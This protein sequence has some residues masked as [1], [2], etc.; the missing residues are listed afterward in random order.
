[1][2][3]QILSTLKIT[4][5]WNTS[6]RERQILYDLP[7]TNN[8]KTSNSKKQRTEWSS[9][10]LRGKGHEEMLVKGYKLLGIRWVSSGDLMYSMVTAVNHTVLCTWKLT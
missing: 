8:L 3:R 6:D 2:V 9:Q 1:M 5:S 4:L 7:Y 10:E